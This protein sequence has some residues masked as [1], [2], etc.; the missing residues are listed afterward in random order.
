MKELYVKNL[1]FTSYESF[2][3]NILRFCIIQQP[4]QLEKFSSQSKLADKKTNSEN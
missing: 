1:G 4:F 2:T 3:L